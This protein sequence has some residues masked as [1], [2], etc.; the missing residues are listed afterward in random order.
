MK[1]YLYPFVLFV[2]NGININAQPIVE[3]IPFMYG[4]DTRLELGNGG[5]I[6]GHYIKTYTEDLKLVRSEKYLYRAGS[7]PLK[8]GRKVI[9]K[10]YL[11]STHLVEIININPNNGFLEGENMD[12]VNTYIYDSLSRRS[13]DNLILPLNMSSGFFHFQDNNSSRRN[14]KYDEIYIQNLKLENEKLNGTGYIIGYKY[15]DQED[16]D[17]IRGYTLNKYHSR[18]KF[19]KGG[20]IR[21]KRGIGGGREYWGAGFRNE[22]SV[23]VRQDTLGTFQMIDGHYVGRFTFEHLGETTLI[24]FN[25][26]GTPDSFTQKHSDG[27]ESQFTV[28]S[29]YYKIKGEIFFSPSI[30]PN[31]HSFKKLT[32]LYIQNN[33]RW[34]NRDTK[35]NDSRIKKYAKYPFISFDIIKGNIGI[36]NNDIRKSNESMLMYYYDTT[37]IFFTEIKD[38]YTLIFDEGLKVVAFDDSETDKIV[39]KYYWRINCYPFYKSFDEPIRMYVTRDK[40]NTYDYFYSCYMKSRDF[41]FMNAPIRNKLFFLFDKNLPTDLKWFQ[42]ESLILD[43]NAASQVKL[44]ERYSNE[45]ELVSLGETESRIGNY[46]DNKINQNHYSEYELRISANKYGLTKQAFLL[47]APYCFSAQYTIGYHYDLCSYEDGQL[48]IHTRKDLNMMVD[49]W[50]SRKM[51]SREV[52]LAIKKLKS[53]E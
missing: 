14:R 16:P 51:K 28:N 45:T 3:K 50:V 47:Y 1:I 38:G 42:Y 35:N 20:K 22:R 41:D 48:K 33:F 7:P 44:K 53:F 23:I 27:T 10:G 25:K 43:L 15:G 26:Y 52:R 18:F 6:N 12:G 19:L 21:I 29:K 11:P 24:E 37:G 13:A 34:Y 49:D 2:L 9:K 39:P 32:E 31:N 30:E 17:P 4:N 36:T 40:E 8:E 46:L 5:L